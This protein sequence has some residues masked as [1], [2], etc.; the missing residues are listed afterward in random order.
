MLLAPPK[1]LGGGI[2]GNSYA[3]LCDADNK[4]LLMDFFYFFFIQITDTVQLL[5]LSF[6]SPVFRSVGFTRTSE[7]YLKASNLN[8]GDIG[9]D[10]RTTVKQ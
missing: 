4:P 10:Y 8:L 2:E 7:Q 9:Q 3:I 6:M 1:T 5:N